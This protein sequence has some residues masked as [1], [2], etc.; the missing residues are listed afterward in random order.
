MI[1]TGR[2]CHS[3]PVLWDLTWSG[4]LLLASSS[5][6]W[7][8]RFFIYP[9]P[10]SPKFLIVKGRDEEAIRVLDFIAKANGKPHSLTLESLARCAQQALSAAHL[11]TVLDPEKQPHAA[12]HL[13]S[14][15]PSPNEKS[16]VAGAT[17]SDAVAVA[18]ELQD[19]ELKRAPPESIPRLLVSSENRSV[20][21]GRDFLS[22]LR[23]WKAEIKRELKRSAS[24]YD[25]ASFKSL[26]HTPRMS[27]N[28]TLICASWGLIG[29]AYRK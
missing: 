16:A 17:R 11:E 27:L 13:L 5:Q 12:D 8:V 2:R 19:D 15:A 3:Q 7:I 24:Q 25:A 20:R 9:I 22:P 23:E 29:C 21:P 28:T 4:S 10:E 18:T 14:G 6:L 26:F 1:A